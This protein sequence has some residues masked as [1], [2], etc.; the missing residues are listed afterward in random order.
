MFEL[1]E[2]KLFSLK[3]LRLNLF[4]LAELKLFSLKSLRLNLFE[5]AELKLFHLRLLIIHL[6]FS[7]FSYVLDFCFNRYIL[8]LIDSIHQMRMSVFNLFPF[9]VLPQIINNGVFFHK[10]IFIM[11]EP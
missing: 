10:N 1:A 7:N 4:E 3:C 11:K 5:L 8:I 6:I 9:V 2:L